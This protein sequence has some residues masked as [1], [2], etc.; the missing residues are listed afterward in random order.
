MRAKA[1]GAARVA[2]VLE[3][4]S[5]CVCIDNCSVAAEKMSR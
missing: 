1:S 5:L 4:A 2:S 3:L